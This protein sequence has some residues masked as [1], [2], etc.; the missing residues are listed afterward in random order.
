MVLKPIFGSCVILLEI[1]R[2]IKVNAGQFYDTF[3][4]RIW[5]LLSYLFLKLRRL[6]V[7][8]YSTWGGHITFGRM[9]RL[10]VLENIW[11]KWATLSWSYIPKWLYFFFNQ[12]VRIGLGEHWTVAQTCQCFVRK[13]WFLSPRRKEI[14]GKT[15]EIFFH[16]IYLSKD[17]YVC[18]AL[19][20]VLLWVPCDGWHVIG[21]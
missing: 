9:G 13:K 18:Y 21:E 14:F 17:R 10:H 7:A 5:H 8:S 15:C 19:L 6:R 16:K 3:E 2:S 12:N 11:W 4:G 1:T 20:D